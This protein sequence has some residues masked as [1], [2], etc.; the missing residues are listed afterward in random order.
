MRYLPETVDL[1]LALLAGRARR[2]DDVVAA[3]SI[4]G[5]DDEVRERLR[6]RAAHHGRS[7]E[8]E[9]RMIL[10]DAVSGPEESDQLFTALM[11]RFAEFGGVDLDLPPR[12]TRPRAA[13]MSE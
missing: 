13:D 7:M 10:A 6:I 11:E 9:I 2:W 1:L 12:S 4:R 8:A 3:L 5:L